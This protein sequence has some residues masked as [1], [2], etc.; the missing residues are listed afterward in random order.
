MHEVTIIEVMIN[1]S[2]LN[3]SFISPTFLVSP[4]FFSVVSFF[5]LRF[6]L[7]SLA[8]EKFFLV[9]FKASIL[10]GLEA[11]AS[12]IVKLF[13]QE[14]VAIGD[15]IIRFVNVEDRLRFVIVLMII[16]SVA[17]SFAEDE[18]D[19]SHISVSKNEMAA[20]LE[21]MRKEGQISE[22]QLK[23]A[24]AAVGGLSDNEMKELTQ[25]GAK[26]AQANDQD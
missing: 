16:F 19:F 23:D 11:F 25:K 2:V 26:Q 7:L 4:T 8:F 18:Y 21:K 17:Q 3:L 10:K 24:K 9:L 22:Q 13:C 14:F 5:T 6:E 20:Q 15:N 1:M 12:R